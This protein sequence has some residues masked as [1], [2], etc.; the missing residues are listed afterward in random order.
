MADSQER[1]DTNRGYMRFRS[2]MHIGMGALYLVLAF[3]VVYLQHFGSI[4]LGKGAAIGLSVLLA[5]YGFFRLW[6]GFTDLRQ[7][8]RNRF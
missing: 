2:I 5:L 6:R 7:M 3:V 4:P 8:K 1:S